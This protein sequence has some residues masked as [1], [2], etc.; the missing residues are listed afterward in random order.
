MWRRAVVGGSRS[1]ELCVLQVNV[2]DVHAG[3]L[4]IHEDD[5]GEDTNVYSDFDHSQ[6]M[7]K[8]TSLPQVALHLFRSAS[9]FDLNSLSAVFLQNLSL[10]SRME[11][12]FRYLTAAMKTSRGA[13]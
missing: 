12:Q 10:Q 7:R 1:H 3:E 2:S 5:P 6:M 4:Y 11:L 9:R 8:M 13:V